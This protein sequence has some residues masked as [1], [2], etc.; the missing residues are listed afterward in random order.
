MSSNEEDLHVAIAA[1]RDL[2]PKRSAGELDEVE[3]AAY[4]RA[5]ARIEAHTTIGEAP[6]PSTRRRSLRVPTERTVT[7]VDGSH[8]EEAVMRNVSEGGMYVETQRPL[9]VGA[10][11]RLKVM[12]AEP[13]EWLE[14]PVEVVWVNQGRPSGIL[15]PGVGVAWV[16]LPDSH[17]RMVQGIVYDELSSLAGREDD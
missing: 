7:L 16:E 6:P 11:L 12:V 4:A 1:F 3:Q 13:A 2:D 9:K 8:T 10:R 17:K 5:R 15:P 14:L